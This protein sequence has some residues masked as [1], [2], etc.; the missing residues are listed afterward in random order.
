MT[1]M[2]KKF[3]QNILTKGPIRELANISHQIN[4]YLTNTKTNF[5]YALNNPEKSSPIKNIGQ[6]KTHNFIHHETNTS[7]LPHALFIINC[8]LLFNE[9]T[10]LFTDICII[11][12][13]TNIA[14]PNPNN[15]KNLSHC[16]RI[17]A[18]SFT[19][20]ARKSKCELQ[21]LKNPRQL[22][23]TAISSF[24]DG[25]A[26]LGQATEMID[27]VFTNSVDNVGKIIFP[28]IKEEYH[29]PGQIPESSYYFLVEC[30]DLEYYS[31]YKHVEHVPLQQYEELLNAT[32]NA[33]L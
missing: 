6:I 19:F 23:L 32:S 12:N 22:P 25:F 26:K 21:Y 24:K 4:N 27:L 16:Y 28:L 5:Q 15:I 18:C 2:I 3:I 30:L 10:P 31:L 17:T 20:K 8:D 14:D 7:Y 29:T 9:R 11:F 1:L 33:F 13:N